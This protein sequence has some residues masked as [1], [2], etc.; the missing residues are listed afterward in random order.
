MVEL[1]KEQEKDFEIKVIAL[2]ACINSKNITQDA[3]AIYE[4]L[5]ESTNEKK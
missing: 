5:K 4:W 2:K 3:I 1:T